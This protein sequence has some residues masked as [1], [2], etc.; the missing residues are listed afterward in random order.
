MSLQIGAIIGDAS[1]TDIQHLHDFGLNIGMAF[2]LQDDILDVYGS[3][4][5]FGKEVGGDI[6]SGKTTFMLLKAFEL[7]KG[8]LLNELKNAM[9]S[10]HVEPLQKVKVVTRIYDQLNVKEI[11]KKKMQHY[12]QLGL[13]HLSEVK[14]DEQKKK[15]LKSF[16]E[17]L[18]VREI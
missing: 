18:M 1:D 16:T 2:Q 6:V 12:H 11:A 14:I 8:V 4:Q 13:K 10:K 15:G 7:A 9:S 17:G 5:K 3:R